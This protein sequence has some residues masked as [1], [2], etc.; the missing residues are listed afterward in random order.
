MGPSV[1]WDGWRIPNRRNLAIIRH[2]WD[3]DLDLLSK[4][5]SLALRYV[6]RHVGVV[7]FVFMFSNVYQVDLHN[8][9][10]VVL[11]MYN[12]S[13]T[14]TGLR[15]E[16]WTSLDLVMVI[17]SACLLVSKLDTHL[18]SISFIIEHRAV[19]NIWRCNPISFNHVCLWC[20]LFDP[21]R[22]AYQSW[23]PDWRKRATCDPSTLPLSPLG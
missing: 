17:T 3:W 16:D 21:H 11:A 10:Y 2:Y 19:V 15:I 6:I 4:L 8:E 13:S 9:A 20:F 18:L 12:E 5:G 7:W 14:K 1:R 22:T 23:E